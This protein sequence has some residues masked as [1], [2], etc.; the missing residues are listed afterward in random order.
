MFKTILGFAALCS[1]ANAAKESS[2][3]TAVHRT[4]LRQVRARRRLP[5]TMCIACKGGLSN[6]DV[7]FDGQY[8]CT[9]ECMSKYI[10]THCCNCD[11]ALEG[12]QVRRPTK[13]DLAGRNFCN[14]KCLRHYVQ[15]VMKKEKE[16]R[17]RPRRHETTVTYDSVGN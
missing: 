1:L 9:E 4:I 8:F 13:G 14:L 2:T 16:D 5:S 17:A 12:K 6:Y 11:N 3:P 15:G 10:N 7:S